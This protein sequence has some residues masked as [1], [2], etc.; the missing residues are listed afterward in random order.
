MDILKRMKLEKP[1]A[2]PEPLES[3]REVHI[4]VDSPTTAN[5]TMDEVEQQLNEMLVMGSQA[6]PDLGVDAHPETRAASRISQS[7]S[8]VSSL[9]RH[10]NPPDTPLEPPPRP[11]SADPWQVDRPPPLS[12]GGRSDAEDIERRPPVGGDSPTLPT[13]VPVQSQRNSSHSS[14]RSSQRNSQ[15]RRTGDSSS[16]KSSNWRDSTATTSSSAT[17]GRF[18]ADSL[19]RRP[20][21][22]NYPLPEPPRYSSQSFD[23]M[24][25]SSRSPISPTSLPNFSK[26]TPIIPE[27]SAIG[28]CSYA[29]ERL[30]I[31]KTF[32]PRQ[33]SLAT[34]RDHYPDRQ[35]SVE[36][37]NSS[38]FD[39]VTFD[40]TTS[41]VTS[42]QRT[43]SIMTTPESPY[44][45]AGTLPQ[46]S[47]H[48]PIYANSTS[49]PF[50]GPMG[51]I[52]NHSSATVATVIHARS[53]TEN[54]EGTVPSITIPQSFE[55]SGLIP[56]EA[57]NREEPSMPAREPDCSI[58]PHSSFYQLKGFCKGAEEIMRGELGCKKIRRPVG[59]RIISIA[60]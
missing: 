22:T 48:P 58:G 9:S 46:Y 23:T 17:D 7:V 31:T 5:R 53:P 56:V 20:A 2:L 47:P 40:G 55:D 41:P 50:S 15:R 60:P 36:S 49:P 44:S 24:S 33:A 51:I 27:D 45:T 57:E 38:I 3:P 43:S 4:T 34:P 35:P 12:P 6:G 39:C 10:S 29:P 30:S 19:G 26:P 59:V 52:A 42:T 37:L 16:R 28:N 11:P 18:R 13:A 14:H 8:D 32:P 25:E 21:Y 54:N 1:V